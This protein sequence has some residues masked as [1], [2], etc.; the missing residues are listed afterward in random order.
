M[1]IFS[2]CS[3]RED[4]P[5]TID[6]LPVEFVG[7]YPLNCWN[8]KTDQQETVVFYQYRY[9]VGRV[10]S[11]RECNGYDDSDFLATYCNGNGEFK[12]VLYASTRFPSSGCGARIDAPP[13]LVDA[14]RED[15]KA[16]QEAARLAFVREIAAECKI[17][18]PTAERLISF[19]NGQGR[20]Y[21]ACRKLLAANLRSEFRKSLAAQLRAWLAEES[22]KYKSPFSDRQWAS[23]LRF[24]R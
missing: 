4:V 18:E 12:E 20:V 11:E 3:K 19:S 14:W 9:A 13:E 7:E 1:P 16:R 15:C 24:E 17:D 8:S 22:P 21:C 23:L 6:G 2:I 5:E 10:V